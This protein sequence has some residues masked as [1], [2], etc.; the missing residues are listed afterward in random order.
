MLRNQIWLVAPALLA[1]FLVSGCQSAG[2]AA[3]MDVE[4]EEHKILNIIDSYVQAVNDADADS[5]ASLFWLGD[6]N[7]SEV[8][9]HIPAP[10]GAKTFS[11]LGDW[12]RKNGNPGKNQRFY[13]TQVYILKPG[14]AYSVSM[15][16]EY[17]T[18]KTSRVTLIY[19]KKGDE[20]R[21][22]HGHFSYIPE[23]V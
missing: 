21:I 5:L 14:V 2:G 22:I 1:A 3:T 17:K 7:F 10:L 19:L 23:Q 11:E 18:N 16:D 9:N 8:E 6:P 15:R 4:S 12:I 13:N 20:W